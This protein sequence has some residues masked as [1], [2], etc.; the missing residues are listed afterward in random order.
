MGFVGSILGGGKGAGFTP[1]APTPQMIANANLDVKDAIKRQQNF[2]NAMQGTQGLQGQTNVFQ[3]EQALANQ[4]GNIAAGQGPNPA[5]A[6]L[7]QATGQNVANQAALM[8]GQ[9]GAGV[10][11]GLI[12][13]Q[14]AQQGGNLQ[15]QSAGQAATMQAQQSLAAMQ[16]Q[17]QQQAMMAQLAGT[18]V[19]QQQQAQQAL[20]QAALQRQ[21]NVFGL[22]QSA[23]Q[24][25][26][27]VAAAT[28]KTQG[29]VLGGMGSA[30]GTAMPLIQKGLSGMGDYF[31]GM[32]GSLGST[33][34]G[35]LAAGASGV[36][37]SGMTAVGA[38][39]EA[40]TSI[41]PAAA[42]VAAEGGEVPKIKSQPTGPRSSYGR[43]LSGVKMASGG[44]VPALVSPG[45]VYLKP[46]DVKQVAAG[47]KAPMDGEK[48]PGKAKV[49]GA[50]N[51][52]ANDTVHKT[53]EEGGIVLPRSVT[54]SKNPDKKAAEFVRAI[55]AKKGR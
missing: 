8:A 19:N 9:R 40:A 41:A 11:A 4:Y 50:K 37:P 55:L 26:G 21:Q 10:N 54:Q 52:Y 36:A 20:A 24:A 5:Q 22:Q 35:G 3:Q 33:V 25:A 32:F 34:G 39:A 27:N 38:G 13:R 29:D 44:K 53:L 51:D 12:A 49:P 43:M 1:Y 28:A 46:N 30:L 7:A 48:I 45:E 42:M 14:A 6:M 17:A 31:G 2:I 16:A 47:R 23:T 18:Q 15:Q